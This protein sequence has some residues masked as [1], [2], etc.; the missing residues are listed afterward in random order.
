MADYK[1]SHTGTQI[2]NAVDKAHTHEN[3]ILLD[4]YNQTNENLSDAV[5]KKH[6][7]TNKAVLDNTTASYTVEEK[8]KLNNLPENPITSETDPTVPTHVKNITEDDILAWNNKSDFDGT[9]NSLTGK[10]DLTLKEDTA[11]KTTTVNSA[12]TDAQYPTAK[13]VHTVVSGKADFSS[14]ST[15]ATSGNYEDLNNKPTITTQVVITNFWKGTQSEY[16]VL[17]T[18]DSTT[19]YLITEE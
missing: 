18:Y 11:N 3:K 14:L 7:H 2:D 4:T 16:E 17:G 10:P 1:S 8:N 19:L 12:S 6:E 15:V 9:Y 5:N 13:A